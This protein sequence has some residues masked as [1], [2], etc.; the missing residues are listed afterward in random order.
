[1]SFLCERGIRA[2]SDV[3][4]DTLDLGVIPALRSISHL[5]LVVDPSHGAGKNH[6]VVPLARAST[7]VG[8]DGLLVE[9]N[10]QLSTG[11]LRSRQELT[12]EHFMHL[13]PDVQ[14]IHRVVIDGAGTA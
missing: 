8:V 12:P 1:M 14:A 5:P 3:T 10:V 9:V 6:L 13:V 2:L 11:S 7:A 4:E